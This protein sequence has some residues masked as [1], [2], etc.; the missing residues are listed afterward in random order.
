MSD[1][2]D[3][4]IKIL[5]RERKIN[6]VSPR[7]PGQQAADTE[8]V[9]P[10]GSIFTRDPLYGDV[11]AM[12]VRFSMVNCGLVCFPSGNRWSDAPKGVFSI[13]SGD[14]G[15]TIADFHATYG[16]KW[17]FDDSLRLSLQ[18]WADQYNP[19]RNT[20]IAPQATIAVMSDTTNTVIKDWDIICNKINDL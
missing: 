15:A 9:Y 19:S 14:I 7:L 2:T 8:K 11:V 13:A 5:E 20:T 18:K 12:L 10:I 3:R 16:D 4:L 6:P 1:L 17:K